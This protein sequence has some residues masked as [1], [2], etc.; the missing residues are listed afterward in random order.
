MDQHAVDT[1]A[2][3]HVRI[4]I[5]MVLGLSVARLLGGVSVFIQHPGRHAVSWIHLGWT[6]FLLLLVIHFWWFE[7]R[8]QGVAHLN[9]AI[10][11]F[12]IAYCSL[13]FLLCC[14]LYPNDIAEYEGY[15]HY[16]MA[17]R[18]WFFGLLALTFATDLA[19]T[20]IKG[21]D[22]FRALGPEYVARNAILAVLCLVAAAVADRRFH[23]AFVALALA[24]QVAWIARAYGALS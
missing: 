9:F 8:L 12:V 23:A 7:F 22:Y 10:Y 16:L 4:V 17:R 5:G 6:A 11:V 21:A 24:W 19:D 20:A 15:G 1:A 2:Y 14:L 3:F 13:F 18:R